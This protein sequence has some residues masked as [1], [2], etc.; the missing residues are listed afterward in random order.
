LKRI[1]SVKGTAAA[2]FKRVLIESVFEPDTIPEVKESELV[3]EQ[4]RNQY[5]E[6]YKTLTKDFYLK[7]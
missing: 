1:T 5:T 3:L 4:A 2:K 7:F 6:E